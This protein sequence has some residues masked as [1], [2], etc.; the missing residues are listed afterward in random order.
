MRR[1]FSFAWI[2]SHL[3]VLFM[4]VFMVNLGFWQLR[5]L[6]ERK[7]SNTEIRTAMAA[8][9]VD[10]DSLSPTEPP[11]AYTPVVVSGQYD[12]SHEMLIANRT[13]ESQSGSWL[14]TPLKL[15]DGRVIAV[16][17]GW[18]PRLWVAGSDTRDASAPSGRVTIEGLTF[19]SLAGGKVAS[20][21]VAGLPELNRMDAS[22]F[23]EVTGLSFEQTWI[24]LQ[25]QVPEQGVL[26][27]PVPVRDLD[28]GPHLS[29]AIQWFFFS[30]ATVVVYYLILK[31]KSEEWAKEA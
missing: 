15:D 1:F 9:P 22:R 13:F 10:F 5:R 8:D 26:P 28:N 24:R 30:T 17:R 20:E 18:V 11:P 25:A 12:G 31:R 27:V 14:V 6:D 19:E 23:D 29:Y 16:V 21:S 7:A 3:F 4:V 2:L